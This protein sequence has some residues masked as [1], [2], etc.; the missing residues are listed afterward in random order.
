MDKEAFLSQISEIGTCEDTST[1]LTLLNNLSNAASSVF[2]SVETLTNSN[3]DLSDKLEKAQNANM[4]LFLSM[5]EKSKTDPT[6]AQ[7]PAGEKRKFENLFNEK[8]EIK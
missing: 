7:E 1:R 6:P 3:N 5:R 8:G 4:Q 2:D